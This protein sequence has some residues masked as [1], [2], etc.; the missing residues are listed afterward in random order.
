MNELR[1]AMLWV[2]LIVAVAGGA[3][4]AAPFVVPAPALQNVFPA[5]SAKQRNSSCPACGLTSGFIAISHGRWNEAQTSNAAAVPLFAMLAGN[6]AFAAAY[7]IRKL[8]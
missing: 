1:S 2:W 4:A 5:C 3:T 8:R 6:F 7:V